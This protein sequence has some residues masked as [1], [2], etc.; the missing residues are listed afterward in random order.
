MRG[1][2]VTGTGFCSGKS[3]ICN[4]LGE[5]LARRDIDVEHLDIAQPFP[6]GALGVQTGSDIGSNGGV[7]S[8]FVLADGFGGFLTPVAPDTLSADVAEHLG[9]PVLIVAAARTDTL[10]D[11]LLTAQAI[12]SRGLSLDGI[13]VNEPT[14]QSRFSAI[15]SVDL[16]RWLN[17]PVHRVAYQFGDATDP[18]YEIQASLA[19]VAA[20]W[21]AQLVATR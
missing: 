5:Y 6:A 2:F 17:H 21:V 9:Y 13:I 20:P 18:E 15:A 14:P 11:I 19:C 3:R 10:N 12:R 8:R 4:A 16:S 1:I 7:Q